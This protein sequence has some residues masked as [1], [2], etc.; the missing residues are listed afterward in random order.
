MIGLPVWNT[1]LG[2]VPALYG[3]TKEVTRFQWVQS[4]QL[5][6]VVQTSAYEQAKIRVIHNKRYSFT[7]L[8]TLRSFC[9]QGLLNN[10]Q[11]SYCLLLGRGIL[12]T[13]PVRSM[14]L[15]GFPASPH[16]VFISKFCLDSGPVWI[17]LRASNSLVP[18]IWAKQNSPSSWPFRHLSLTLCWIQ[19]SNCYRQT[20]G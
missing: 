18:I 10:I 16:V 15:A 11:Q 14:R 3:F 20:V 1:I 13:T 6:L 7:Y 12:L 17:S 5:N 4:K 19:F 9:N 2:G 8:L